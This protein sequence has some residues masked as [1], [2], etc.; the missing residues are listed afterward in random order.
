MKKKKKKDTNALRMLVLISQ[1]GISMLVPILF[2]VYLGQFLGE[3]FHLEIIFPIILLIGV[4]AGFR[5]C[6]TVI[7]RFV[8]LGKKKTEKKEYMRKEESDRYEMDKL[9]SGRK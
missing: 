8:N 6:Y 2:C 4:M 5:S 1:L 7:T 3:K 9:D